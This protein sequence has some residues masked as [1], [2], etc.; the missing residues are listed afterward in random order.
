MS[1]EGKKQSTIFQLAFDEVG[2]VITTNGRC[3]RDRY[4]I[5]DPP[6]CRKHE[7]IKDHFVVRPNCEHASVSLVRWTPFIIQ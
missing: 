1:I 6:H 2:V 7:T 4:R 5:R 3:L